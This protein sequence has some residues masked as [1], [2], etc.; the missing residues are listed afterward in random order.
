M[1]LTFLL[2]RD[3]FKESQVPWRICGIPT[4][5]PFEIW[6]KLKGILIS[7]QKVAVDKINSS[8][9]RRV[10]KC[11]SE[12]QTTVDLMVEGEERTEH[13][14]TRGLSRGK[15][16]ALLSGPSWGTVRMLASSHCGVGKVFLWCESPKSF[17]GARIILIV[18]AI[19]SFCLEGLDLSFFISFP[20]GFLYR[21]SFLP[22][23]SSWSSST[24][25]RC[26]PGSGVLMN[27]FLGWY[28]LKMSPYLNI[29][30]EQN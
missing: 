22:L 12:A 17:S 27:L 16:R 4:V 9:W 13:G 19:N 14:N 24:S 18:S 8:L 29:P 11:F 23:G 5:G 2:K 21:I 20:R 30:F 6:I 15:W 1:R 7:F 3:D 28:L 10:L 26:P 25:H